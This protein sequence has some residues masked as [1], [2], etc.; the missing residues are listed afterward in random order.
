MPYD[1]D[2]VANLDAELDALVS[3]TTDDVLA[4]SRDYDAGFVAASA[5]RR[6]IE[7]GGGPGGPVAAEDVTV[8]PE[9]SGEADVQA[10]LEALAAA[11]GSQ[12]FLFGCCLYEFVETTGAGVYEAELPVAAHGVIGN[13]IVI[14]RSDGGWDDTANLDIFDSDNG[15]HCN[16]LGLH[17]EPL[18]EYTPAGGTVLA[19]VAG[20][21]ESD[22][23]LG[24]DFAGSYWF[25]DYRNFFN[26]IPVVVDTGSGIGV[27]NL[28]INAAQM[29]MK[30]GVFYDEGTT[31]TLRVTAAGGSNGRTQVYVYGMGLQ[32]DAYTLVEKTPA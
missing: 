22:D 20:K 21:M 11:V 12:P 9:V 15:Y 25:V 28:E 6:A 1:D 23:G 24:G 32:G 30:P 2:Q 31:I 14:A 26:A 8:D 10:A 17:N 3:P 13:V 7:G 29:L 4:R 19:P 5:A 18:E 27:A 16:G